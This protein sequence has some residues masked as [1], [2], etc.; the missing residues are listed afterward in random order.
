MLIDVDR[1]ES[2]KIILFL[3]DEKS[4]IPLTAQIHLT[5]AG[6]EDLKAKLEP[7]FDPS[8]QA[9]FAE[10]EEKMKMRW[11]LARSKRGLRMLF[12]A[13]GTV[14]LGVFLE[15]ASG[16]L[17]S[18]GEEFIKDFNAILGLER[19]LWKT[20]EV[21]SFNGKLSKLW[22]ELDSEDPKELPQGSSSAPALA[23]SSPA[24]RGD[25]SPTEPP[26]SLPDTEPPPAAPP[27][28]PPA[29]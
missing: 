15:S 10:D 4:K 13:H 17:L 26:S 22:S 27:A 11:Q 5:R 16:A 8:A 24:P 1:D 9:T 25:S 7:Y 21:Q 3:A 19:R 14:R 29:Q 28:A 20:S 18:F 23:A 2:G 6:W 12:N